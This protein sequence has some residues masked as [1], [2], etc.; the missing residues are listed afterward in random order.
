M[1]HITQVSQG[2]YSHCCSLQHFPV[3]FA[4]NFAKGHIGS[5][6]FSIY[7]FYWDNPGSK[8]AVLITLHLAGC[9]GGQHLLLN[10]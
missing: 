4:A 7:A 9:I 5:W 10:G 8:G 2:N 1:C 3:G 6:S